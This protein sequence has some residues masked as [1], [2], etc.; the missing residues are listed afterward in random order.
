MAHLSKRLSAICDMVPPCTQVVD[1]GC[2]HAYLPIE[3]IGRKVCERAVASDLREGPLA[4]ARKNIEDSGL[5]GKIR[6]SLADGIPKDTGG[7]V[8]VISGMGGLLTARILK[9]GADLLPSFEALVLEPQSHLLTVRKAIRR[10]GYAIEDEDMVE[11]DGK[12]YPILLARPGEMF[13]SE[14]E[15]EFGPVLLRERD[16]VLY[17]YLKK[18][19]REQEAICRRIREGGAGSDRLAEPKRQCLRIKEALKYY[20]DP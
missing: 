18:R 10:F 1:V 3:L 8:L 19:E 9:E 14:V 15:E 12:V 7:G 13:L 4:R 17:R 16:P 6:L 5:S 11:E 2:D 20:E